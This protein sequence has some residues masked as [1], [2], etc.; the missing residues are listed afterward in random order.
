MSTK[1]APIE[2]PNLRALYLALTETEQERFARLAGTTTGYIR[3]HLIYGRK[4]P[5][6]ALLDGLVTACAAMRWKLSRADLLAFFYTE[7]AAA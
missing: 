1:P 3:A 6:R 5:R 4:V 2:Q 7:R